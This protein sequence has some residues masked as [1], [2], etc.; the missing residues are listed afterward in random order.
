VYKDEQATVDKIFELK[1]PLHDHIEKSKFLY[2]PSRPNSMP[3][4][5]SSWFYNSTG[6]YDRDTTMGKI[7]HMIYRNNIL[8][9]AI[10]M[11]V[12][13]TIFR[14]HRKVETPARNSDACV[15]SITSNP[16]SCKD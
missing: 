7:T 11:V 3:D 16:K 1:S 5:E 8:R 12:Q 13:A 4:D 14:E 2:N 10:D 9:R 6:P 15:G